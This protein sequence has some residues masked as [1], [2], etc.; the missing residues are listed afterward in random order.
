MKK[1]MLDLAIRDLSFVINHEPDH[2]DSLYSR[3]KQ[4][5]LTK[6][7]KLTAAATYLSCRHDFFEDG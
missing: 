2:V 1:G 3:G 5:H 7:S 4:H 6:D